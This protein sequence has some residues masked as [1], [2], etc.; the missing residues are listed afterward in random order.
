MKPRIYAFADEAADDLEGQIAA[1]RENGLDGLE[2]RNV[3]GKN[4]AELSEREAAEIRARLDGAGLKVWSVGSPIGKTGI[5]DGDFKKQEERFK[6]A[7]NIADILGAECFRLFSFYIPSGR[8]A[9]EYGDIVTE[10]LGRLCAAADGSDVTLCHENEKGIYGDMAKRCARIHRALPKLKG[11]FD[12]ANFIQCGEDTLEAWR[13]LKPY[14]KYMHIKDALRSGEVVPAGEGIGNIGFIAA[15]FA[16][17]GGKCFTVE[18]H[19]AVFAGFETLERGAAGAAALPPSGRF[20]YASAREA[21][22][23]ACRSFGN[24]LKEEGLWK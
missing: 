15:D 17:A 6:R 20:V 2:I 16:A 5:E 23:A 10:R 12:P 22:D 21:F 7:L 18:P 3:G 4:V 13:L 8:E 19:L 9:D 1:M 24:I 14:I 11:V